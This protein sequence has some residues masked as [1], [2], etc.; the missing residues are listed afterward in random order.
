MKQIYVHV[1]LFQA[2]S[3]Q[4]IK[5]KEVM[6]SFG[7]VDS[8]QDKDEKLQLPP[9]GYI[10]KSRLSCQGVVDQTFSIANTAGVNA[11]IFACEFE[12]FSELLP[13]YGLVNW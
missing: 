10:G 12:R 4:A 7:F 3:E 6:R 2:T 1:Q 11:H 9:N 13:G 8:I 5:F